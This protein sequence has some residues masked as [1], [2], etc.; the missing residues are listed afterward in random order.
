MFY[1]INSPE[2]A[3]FPPIIDLNKDNYTEPKPIA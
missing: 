2:I 1:F 3:N